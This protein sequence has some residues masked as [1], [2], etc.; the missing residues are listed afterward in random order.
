MKIDANRL[1]KHIENL[2]NVGSTREGG[3]RRLALTEEDRDGRDHIVSRMKD[4]GLVVQ[5]DQI[6]NIFGIRTGISDLPPVM[7][8]SH[9][10]TVYNG[11]KLDGNLGVLA[12]LE[13]V[14]VLNSFEVKTNRSFIVGVFTNEEG[15]RFQPD[16]MGSLVYAGGYDLNTA[17][18]AESSKGEVL[19]EELDNIGYAGDMICG[20]IIPHAFIELHIE[21]G[22]ILEAQE[23][24]IGAVE[25][26]QGI[27]WTE[28]TITGEANHAGTTPMGM[29][30]DA[31]TCAGE[32]ISFVHQLANDFGEPQ[33]ATVGVVELKPNIINV[34]PGGARVTVDLRNP[35]NSILKDAERN[36]EEFLAEVSLKHTVEINSKRLVRFDPVKFD[37]RIVELIEHNAAKLELKC[38]RMT[39]GA[40]H[41]A[42]MMSRICPTA[43]IFVPSINGISHNPA[44]STDESDLVAGA[45]VLLRT[46]LDLLND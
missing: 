6:G 38:R 37:A 32:I 28:I 24:S 5:I 8:G 14:E 44:E 23:Y 11:G 12:G 40:G 10:D 29:R 30:K 41:D 1:L 4:L 3:V 35:D 36:L 43:M 25:N 13:I 2:G 42:Q 34:V 39:S 46:V 22:P 7:T 31:G 18:N 27:S 21:Q 45:D 19:G 17:L 9:I 26:L 15:A 20:S 16:M 33:V